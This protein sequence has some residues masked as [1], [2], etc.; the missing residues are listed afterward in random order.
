[1]RVTKRKGF[2]L[3]ELLIVIVVIGI[4]ASGMMLASGSATNSAK[5]S[6]AIADLRNAKAAALLWFADHLKEPVI[7]FAE[8]D[9]TE[10]GEKIKSYMDNDTK[11]MYVRGITDGSSIAYVGLLGTDSK[12]VQVM[13]KISSQSGGN[14]FFTGDT[15]VIAGG[16]L[17]KDT[18]Q[19]TATTR[20]FGCG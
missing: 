13:K 15:A 17:S 20:S 4:L 14:I 3:V 8:T 1:M 6:T 5:A 2:T 7:A 9:V 12:D 19:D 18:Y 10:I 16:G 11:A